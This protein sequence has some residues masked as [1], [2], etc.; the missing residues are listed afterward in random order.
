MRDLCRLILFAVLLLAPQ[1]P[2]SAD[3]QKGLDAYNVGDYETSLAEC[4]PAAEAGDA[5][6][7]FC[8]GR[9]YANG[10]GVAMDDALA[11][12]WYELAAQQGHAEALYSLGLMHANGWG[13]PM[14]DAV[15]AQWYRRA[16]ELGFPMAQM[17]LA[18]LCRTGRGVPQDMVE[19]FTWYAVAAEL[20]NMNAG[21]K[22]DEI[23]P[24]LN[25]EQRQLAE[26]RAQAW[27]DANNGDK[28][29]VDDLE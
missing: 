10:F 3:V 11:L 27:L 7:Q 29:H 26:E 20:G 25:E 17:S 24:D 4:Q 13:V 15:A 16:A 6:A 22:L 19:A 9:L 12:K 18:N 2:V 21:F 1:T 8:I 28:I 23:A 14:D 5:R